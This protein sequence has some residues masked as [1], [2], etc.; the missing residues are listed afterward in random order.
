MEAERLPK[1]IFLCFRLLLVQTRS[2]IG[3]TYKDFAVI[4]A[5]EYGKGRVLYN[6]LGHREEVWGRPDIQKMWV[7]MVRWSMGN[8]PGDAAPRPASAR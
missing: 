5:R 2:Q 4:W 7:D 3:M 8:L 1:H 6:G